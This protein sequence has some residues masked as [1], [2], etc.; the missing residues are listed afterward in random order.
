[1]VPWLAALLPPPER[2]MPSKLS[3][4]LRVSWLHV[5]AGT[6]PP[7]RIFGLSAKSSRVPKRKRPWS[8]V[9]SPSQVFTAVVEGQQIPWKVVRPSY[10]SHTGTTSRK[11]YRLGSGYNTA[12][13]GV[14]AINRLPSRGQFPSVE[15]LSG[16]TAGRSHPKQA[17]KRHLR[18]GPH[19]LSQTG[20]VRRYAELHIDFSLMMPSITV[21][22]SRD[23]KSKV[24]S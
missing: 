15:T 10:R 16:Q 6:L 17:C 23:F 7:C 12:Q 1:M 19:A 9:R 18:R 8:T 21:H 13:S 2:V 24:I 4:W 14:K 20:E 3:V 22:H 5:A 11:I